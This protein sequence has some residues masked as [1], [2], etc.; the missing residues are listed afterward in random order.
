[1][2]F[3]SLE[4][5]FLFLPL[6]LAIYFIVPTKARNAVLL[7]F[8]LVFYG[9]G[10]PVYLFLMVAT[11]LV[12]W[13]LGLAIERFAKT[14]SSKK[15]LLVLAVSLNILS[16]AFF[17]YYDFI[18]SFIPFASPL[19]LSLPI[20]I[21]FYTFQ[22]LT[23]VIDIYRENAKAATSPLLPATYITL[24]PQLI[25]G[26]IVKYND[27]EC[28]LRSRIHSLS[29]LTYGIRRFVIGLAKKVL[30]AN[31]AGAMFE[32]IK[33]S[34]SLY[35]TD[36]LGAWL[37]VIFF[38]FQIYFDFSGYSDMAIG[39]G[40][41][42]GFTFPENFNYPYISVSITDFW[43]R[44]HITLSSF[45]RD[46]LYIPLGG[47]RRG[48]LR[49]YINLFIVWSAT[50]IWH[51][52]GINFLLWGLYFFILLSTEKLFLLTLLKKL[53][54]FFC[55]IYAIVAILFGW[56][57]FASDGITLSASEAFNLA[58]AMLGI[59]S[60]LFSS[61]SLY[62][63]KRNLLPIAIMCAASIPAFSKLGQKLLDSNSIGKAVTNLLSSVLFILCT[64]Y[65]VSSGYNPFLYFRF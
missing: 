47:N 50:G 16:L 63:F 2:L 29:S 13:F 51:G 44:W 17:K 35:G 38:A 31:T 24:F 1:M 6:C 8:S 34:S 43:R 53:P 15:A 27:I 59:S 65:L 55:H 18:V 54:K 25:A 14:A 57:I 39:L 61:Y 45:F 9:F 56:L 30:L 36:T 41:L 26:P 40:K 37:C 62:E 10:E 49:T 3:S 12:D 4:F 21:S 11:I 32:S 64:A 19:G 20:G 42:F 58:K 22:S 60:P 7:L 5:L 52:A 28:D 33:N 23:Y 48:K 46:Y